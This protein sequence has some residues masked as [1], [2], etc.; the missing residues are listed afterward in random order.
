MSRDKSYKKEKFVC[1]ECGK[2]WDTPG[3][4][5]SCWDRHK[6]MDVLERVYNHKSLYIED[7]I[8]AIDEMVRAGEFDSEDAI[9]RELRIQ[10]RRSEAVERDID[11]LKAYIKKLEAAISADWKE[12]G[13]GENVHEACEW[14]EYTD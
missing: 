8:E 14:K 5:S 13:V 11:Q 12:N 7:V 10:E 2:E 6:F 3:A 1:R 9:D 4:A